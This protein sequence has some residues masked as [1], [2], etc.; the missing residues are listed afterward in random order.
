[1][2]LQTKTGVYFD[3]AHRT[4]KSD[5]L[6]SFASAYYYEDRY[7]EKKEIIMPFLD[8][9]RKEGK[10]NY[11]SP[12][13]WNSS[14][15]ISKELGLVDSENKVNPLVEKLLKGKISKSQYM[16]NILLNY[17]SVFM[18]EYEYRAYK[19][20]IYLKENNLTDIKKSDIKNWVEV[21]GTGDTAVDNTYEFLKNKTT[22]FYETI[23]D[24]ELKLKSGV[25]VNNAISSFNYTEKH[26]LKEI[27]EYF[28]SNNIYILENEDLIKI[29]GNSDKDKLNSLFYMLKDSLFFEGSLIDPTKQERAP[30]I[31]LT[32][33]WKL[34]E[35][36]MKCLINPL[37][38]N[39]DTQDEWCK[40]LNRETFVL[41][42]EYRST[43][44][45]QIPGLIND[46]KMTVPELTALAAI[47][48]NQEKQIK[49]LRNLKG[50]YN[51]INYGA[52]GTGKSYLLNENANRLFN[53]E[54]IQRVTFYQ[55]Y[56]YSQFVGSYKPK[57]KEDEKITY[58]YVPGIFTR[59][60]VEALK[61]KDQL[62]IIEEINRTKP[63]AVFGDIFQLLDRDSNGKSE[64]SIRPTEEM[65]KYFREDA[66][67]DYPEVVQK[68]EREGLE[69]PDSMYIWST[70]NSADQNVYP[71]D[72]AFKRRW[73]FEYI[74]LDDNKE[75][76]GKKNG[77]NHTDYFVKYLDKGNNPK[78]ITWNDFREILNNFLVEDVQ[79]DRLIAPFFVKEEAFK[80][81]NGEFILN[82]KIFFSKILMYLFDD[83]LKHRKNIKLF[84]SFKG[85][86]KL[87]K[88]YKVEQNSIFEDSFIEQL[89]KR[90]KVI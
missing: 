31:K 15:P 79:E 48:C 43:D 68:I 73:D 34:D 35:L 76:F 12:E 47:G 58:E 33:K 78:L 10:K 45:C 18:D 50:E 75:K 81:E 6:L 87:K 88:E 84:K 66:L 39:P 2:P 82:E 90:G 56:S 21:D 51:I 80:E 52:P 27:L 55:G 83:V 22:Y 30:N 67:K 57:P 1:M 77:K 26:L 17:Y 40:I 64:Y 54:K 16:S 71:M 49:Y 69:I 46:I 13:K 5:T 53:Q 8:I 7:G 23:P 85:L 60:L 9:Y 29:F 14:F 74:G 28:K 19:T 63:D 32:F 59:T 62:L 72:T 65:M 41:C 4:E 42:E 20:C 89:D 3:V 36:K 70:M 37:K 25:T 11:N 61:G 24:K 38:L 44:E 86:S